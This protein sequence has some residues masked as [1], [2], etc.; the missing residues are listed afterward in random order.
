M[1]LDCQELF[2]SVILDHDSRPRHF[3]AIEDATHSASGLNPV[4]GD[5]Y[6]VFLDVRE[7]QIRRA[8]F[9]GRGCAISKASASMMVSMIEG[10]TVAEARSLRGDLDKSLHPQESRGSRE[11]QPELPGELEALTGVREHPSRIRC[12][13]LAWDAM[14][15]ALSSPDSEPPQSRK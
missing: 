11:A 15:Q 13:M 10:M 8:S 7:G 14:T 6:R 2:Q 3:D 4:C 1:S 12:V 9:H 5:R